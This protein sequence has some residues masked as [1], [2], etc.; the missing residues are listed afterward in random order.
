MLAKAIA[1]IY[2]TFLSLLDTPSSYS[3][4][5]GKYVK[6]NTGETGLEFGTM[7]DIDFRDYSPAANGQKIS[8][9][10]IT[11]GLATLT[12]ASGLFVSGDVGKSCVVTGA[13]V[14]G[15]NLHTTIA[16]YTNSNTLTLTANASTTVSAANFSW[17]TDDT[18]K[19]QSAIDAALTVGGAR[20]S[21]PI[22]R[23]YC[24]GILTLKRGVSL[25]GAAEGPFDPSN[26]NPGKNKVTPCLMITNESSDFITVNNH[27]S[28]IEKLCF[29]YPNQAQPT[30]TAPVVYP[31]TLV[32]NQGVAGFSLEETT[33]INSY[34][35]IR[36]YGGRHYIDSINIGALRIGIL[37]DYSL[38]TIRLN[39]I[40]MTPF[41][42]TVNGLGG[43]Q[44]LDYWT[45]DNAKGLVIYRADLTIINSLFMFWK[46]IG[47]E[48]ADSPDTGQSPR[49]SYGCGT[50]INIDIC[51]Y[52]IKA[53]ATQGGSGSG[54]EWEFVNM[55]LLGSI[56]AGYSGITGV[57]LTTGGA[58]TPQVK[59]ISG[60]FWGTFTDKSI[61]DAGS[62][63]NFG[64][65][66]LTTNMGGTSLTVEEID[67]SP[68]VANVN[69]VRFTNGTV[70]NDG[71]GVVTVTTG[72]T[73]LTVKEIDGAPSV[74][75]V[76]T[77]RFS[78][79][80]VTDDGGGI[81]T[82]TTGGGDLASFG[83]DGGAFTDVYI[84]T[85]NVDGG[86]F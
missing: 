50:N 9:A 19:F 4:Q 42:D 7:I 1:K 70:T 18:A 41:W 68:S 78:N 60:T 29:Y 40:Q 59:W 13:G 85:A 77:V 72:G 74:A 15:A 71:G 20:I 27:Q 73:A 34:D 58:T 69:T 33:F 36:L 75:N 16:G 82:V 26:S 22:N 67:G 83:I 17:G 6:V 5:A 12:S 39:N 80:T 21:I 32:V 25:V 23:Y 3:G 52:G 35:A 54:M 10:G 28:K 37:I 30:A 81:V 47:I 86:A 55:Q 76:N 51:R 46:Y 43:G 56:Y 45:L 44:N 49:S 66:G 63:K 65:D 38:D 61:I 24:T 31:Y 8:D 53:S 62:L 14:A 11:S 57:W 84:S 64:V 79:G 2:S 48:L